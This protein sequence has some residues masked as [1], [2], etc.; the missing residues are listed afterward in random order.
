MTTLL[1]QLVGPM[2]AWGTQSRYGVRDTGL[3]PSKS[4]VVGLLAA[5]LGRP[6]HY[7][8]SD[9]ARLRM[10]VRVDRE[11]KLESDYHTASDVLKS[12]GGIKNTEVSRRY[13]LA[14]A[15]FL[16]GLEGDDGFLTEIQ[17][18]LISPIWPLFLGR[19]AFV[20]S[21]PVFLE[22]GLYMGTGLEPA[23]LT[24]QPVRPSRSIVTQLRVV[25]DDPSGTEVR[26]DMP[27]SFS[28]RT[29][30][31]RRVKTTFVPLPII[32]SSMHLPVNPSSTYEVNTVEEP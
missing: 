16:V 7:D 28:E 10:A 32:H 17:D 11:G 15:A 25:T 26:N 2:Q 13:F 31:T 4:G 20:P 27:I 12:Q 3:E 1:I 14:D 30:S 18:A 9:L 21:Q 6:R 24:R 22:D 8:M 29:F 23:L 5:A 19:K